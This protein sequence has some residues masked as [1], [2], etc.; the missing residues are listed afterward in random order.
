MFGFIDRTSLLR[1]VHR[2][3]EAVVSALALESARFEGNEQMQTN[4]VME[5]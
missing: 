4:N 3:T 1:S 2:S 5:I